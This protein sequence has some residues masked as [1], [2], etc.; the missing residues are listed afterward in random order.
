MALSPSSPLAS[1]VLYQRDKTYIPRIA[2]VHD[3]CG[4]GNCSL[5]AALPILSAAGCDARPVPTAVFSSHTGYESFVFE[6]TTNF[7]PSYFDS[8]AKLHVHLDGI[9]SGFLGSKEQVSLIQR[10]YATHPQALRFVDPVMGDNGRLYPTYT[11]EMCNEMKKLVDGADILFP[12]ITEACL[13][14]E[15]EY[16]GANISRN[17]VLALTQKLAFMGAHV[18]VLKG[19]DR[20]DGLLR[21]VIYVPRDNDDPFMTEVAHEKLPFMLHGTGDAFASAVIGAVMAGLPVQESVL[22][23]G[24]FI[25]DAMRKSTAQPGYEKRGVSFELSLHIMTDLIKP[26]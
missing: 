25:I 10:L 11:R 7:I 12:N 24:N 19:I 9:Y 18:I 26:S 17:E 13:L 1:P 5:T 21:N 4:I 16:R 2:A 3:I 23:A 6:D 22:L 8:W 15:T 14:T 20:N